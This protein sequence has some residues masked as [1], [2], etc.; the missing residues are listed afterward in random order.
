[1]AFRACSMAAAGH[2]AR[3][4]HD[5]GDVLGRDFALRAGMA[6]GADAEEKSAVLAAESGMSAGKIRNGPKRE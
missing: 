3:S 6:F 4:V 5:E 2:A 1:M